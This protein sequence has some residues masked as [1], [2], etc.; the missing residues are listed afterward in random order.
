MFGLT[1]N[2]GNHGEDVKEY[3]FYL[4]STPTHSYMKYL[5]KYP[6]A[7]F[8]YARLVGRKS[9][10]EARANRNSN[11]IDTGVFEENRYF[12]VFVEY[13]KAD[14][15]RY[16]DQDHGREP[17]AG[18]SAI[19]DC[20]RRYGS[21]TPGHGDEGRASAGTSRKAIKRTGACDRTETAVSG[22]GGCTAKARRN[23]CSP[24]T[25]PT[26]CACSECRTARRM[27]RTV[28]IEYVVNGATDAVNPGADRNEGGGALQTG[29]RRRGDRHG[30]VTSDALRVS[31]RT[32]V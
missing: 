32:S 18:S 6:Q 1:G 14:I 16:P 31:R 12:D 20:C 4:D 23:C 13:A 25:K 9:T 10:G 7:E 2:E 17:R 3:Y 27:S 26:R 21:A 28:S 22:S 8:P 30:P 19:C 11:C 5:Y 24:R 29:N 15:G